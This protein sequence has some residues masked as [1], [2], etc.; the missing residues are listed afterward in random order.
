MNSRPTRITIRSTALIGMAA[1]IAGFLAG[2]LPAVATATHPNPGLKSP[3]EPFQAINLFDRPDTPWGPGHRGIDL[4]ASIGQEVLAPGDGV[5]TFAGYIVDRG[6]VSI[7]HPSGL[8]SSLEPV[9]PTVTAGMVVS[10][11]DSVGT[12]TD[13]RG[14][15]APQTCLH[16]GV[17]RNGNYINPL[18]VLAGFG[19]VRL[20]PLSEGPGRI[21]HLTEL[22]NGRGMDLRNPGLRHSENLT[23]LPKVKVLEVIHAKHLLLASTDAIHRSTEQ[24]EGFPPVNEG[25]GSGDPKRFGRHLVGAVVVREHP[26]E[27][28]HMGEGHLGPDGSNI[29]DLPPEP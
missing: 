14:H 18:D 22:G 25:A 20:L 2:P 3:A 19:P 6:V 16:W 12:I 17:R 23:D 10:S 24:V 13:E 4:E 8:V 26:I 27:R 29:R 15:C 28:G 11:G 5:V 1:L 7:R 21:E 9:A